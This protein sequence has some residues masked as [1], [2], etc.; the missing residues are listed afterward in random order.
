MK[1]NNRLIKILLII[2][3]VCISG[4]I[5]FLSSYSKQIL[6][7]HVASREIK[8]SQNIFNV[9]KNRDIGA[10][11][12]V[13][14]GI[15]LD[16]AYKDLFLKGDRLALYNYSQ[17][18]FRNIKDDYEITHFYFHLPDGTNF[19]RIHDKSKFNDKINRLTFKQAVDSKSMGSGIELGQTAFA[20]RVV[21]PYY[22]GDKLIGYVE[23]GQE[24]DHFLRILKETTNDNYSIFVDKKVLN[25]D[26]WVTIRTAAGLNSNWES[27]KNLVEMNSTT[28]SLQNEDFILNCLNETN[29]Q[30]VFDSKGGDSLNVGEIGLGTSCGGFDLLDA[31]NNKIGVVLLSSDI[32]SD[33]VTINSF[34]Y[35]QVEFVVILIVLVFLVLYLISNRSAQNQKK[36]KYLFEGSDDAILTLS[37]P[38]WKFVDANSAAL[39]VYGFKTLSQLF[40]VLPWELSPEY[41]PNGKLSADYA[42]EMI[43]DAL[44]K[45]TNSFDW[46]HKRSNGEEF[47]A[48]VLLTKIELGKKVILQAIIH[49]VTKQKK[50][51]EVLKKTTEET[52]KALLE[53]ERLN[54]LMIGRELE[55]VRLKKELMENK[56]TK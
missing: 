23:L 50:E 2:S 6:I 35:R 5:Y 1:K 40:E 20:L 53:T 19:V 37:P 49:D 45:G 47:F 25:K 34:I 46:I 12:S 18:F 32:S 29:A 10:M 36:Y 48:N 38:D 7:T 39:R 42:R 15:M 9:I 44:K 28:Q 16:K 24:M 27:F 54:K 3:I 41:Q 22:D 33:L 21:K 26:N 30:K 31:S 14:D 17:P 13:L 8:N 51:A 56:N 11:S 55:M 52:K 4:Y 43:E